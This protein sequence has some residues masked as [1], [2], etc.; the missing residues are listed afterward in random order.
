MRRIRHNFDMNIQTTAFK[1]DDNWTLDV[2]YFFFTF[3][4]SIFFVHLE[5]YYEKFDEIEWNLTVLMERFRNSI[6]KPGLWRKR[7]FFFNFMH[8]HI[9]LVINEKKGEKNVNISFH[10][11]TIQ[12]TLQ[13]KHS[14]CAKPQLKEYQTRKKLYFSKKKLFID[15]FF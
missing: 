6:E 7:A 13:L 12:P 2:H 9:S 10:W 3:S 4:V 11:K 5:M 8:G 14:E 1:F 15:C